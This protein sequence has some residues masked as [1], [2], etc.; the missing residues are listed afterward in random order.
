MQNLMEGEIKDVNEINMILHHMLKRC[1]KLPEGYD[2][3]E[4]FQPLLGPGG[5]AGDDAVL[6]SQLEAL[7]PTMEDDEDGHK[8]LWDIVCELHG[9]ESVRIFKGRNQDWD[10]RCLVVRC[11]IDFQFLHDGVQV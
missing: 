10:V 4:S 9:R 6:L 11:L 8:G 1:N 2:S 5:K 7:L 3:I